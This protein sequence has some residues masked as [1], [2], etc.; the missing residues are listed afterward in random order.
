MVSDNDI[1]RILDEKKLP[2]FNGNRDLYHEWKEL[3]DTMVTAAGMDGIIYGSTPIP[4]VA[5][6][7]TPTADEQ[8]VLR[9]AA[10]MKLVMLASL[11]GEARSYVLSTG[12]ENVKQMYDKLKTYQTKIGNS[13]WIHALLDAFT[14]KK[15]L[16][17]TIMTCE[18]VALY[19][20]QKL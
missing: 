9:Y 1:Y 17:E 14:D 12:G 6:G 15:N 4:F 18:I 20:C 5:V 3:W 16:T 2:K 7:S 13:E 19:I 11:E 10:H 8:K